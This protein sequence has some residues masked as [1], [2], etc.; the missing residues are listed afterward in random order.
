MSASSVL[1]A[2]AGDDLLNI[3]DEIR[4]HYI[5]DSGLPQRLQL[6]YVP[7]E[8]EWMSF[9]WVQK[10]LLWTSYSNGP[11]WKRPCLNRK[12]RTGMGQVRLFWICDPGGHWYHEDQ[13]LF[14]GVRLVLSVTCL[15]PKRP[16]AARLTEKAE[17]V[18]GA[19]RLFQRGGSVLLKRSAH[20]FYTKCGRLVCDWRHTNARVLAGEGA[21]IAT[22]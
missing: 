22:R 9:A 20:S 6:A 12:S 13:F 17:P 21:K 10:R 4:H 19:V 1:F 11:Y 14:T 2:P 3:V 18:V 16:S 5:H 8:G 7:G 15:T